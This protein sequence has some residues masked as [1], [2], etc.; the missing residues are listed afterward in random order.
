MH[1]YLYLSRKQ[2]ITLQNKR[3]QAQIISIFYYFLY[4]EKIRAND[5][6]LYLHSIY[7]LAEIFLI[8]SL[9]N[10]KDT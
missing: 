6:L 10:N 2:T 7:N 1:I 5:I 4:N 3:Y 8:T 9:K